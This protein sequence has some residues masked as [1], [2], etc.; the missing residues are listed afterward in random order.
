MLLNKKYLITRFFVV[1]IAAMALVSC[2]ETHAG[3]DLFPDTGDT[4]S[5]ATRK[6][7][8]PQGKVFIYMA[9]G[10]NNLVNYLS[11][12]IEELAA[13]PLP[14]GLWNDDIILVFS[15]KTA[16]YHDYSTDTSPTLTRLYRGWDGSVTRDTLMVMD[17]STAS[18]SA[19]TIN[20][21]LTYIHEM[22]PSSSYGMLMSSHGTGWAPSN[23]SNDP[24]RYEGYSSSDSGIWQTQR[25]D[26]FIAKPF[27]EDLS[28]DGA[29]A[30]KGIGVQNISSSE[31]ME[32]NVT[33]LADAIPMKMDYIIFDACLMG[34][35][36]VAYEFRDICDTM[37]CSQT[38]ILAD[39]MDYSTMLSYLFGG[40]V[41]DLR[42]FC[43]NFYRY[44]NS[45]SGTNRSATIS[46]IDCNSLEPLAAFCKDYFTNNRDRIANLEGAS[47][48]QKYF[49]SS[50]LGWF[51]DLADII[52]ES[53][54]SE[55]QIAL[56]NEALDE[57]IL[58]KAATPKFI[59]LPINSHCGISMYLPYKS[60][61]YLN[62]FYKTLEWN[63]ATGLVQ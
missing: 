23:Y 11:S 59:D 32:I 13:S 63:K 49:R 20:E 4:D 60:R 27:L 16:K 18:A 15:H 28:V 48:V 36:E 38:E 45:K 51:F 34:G 24:K 17:K 39:G 53:G 1:A 55:E 5:A 26:K 6:P 40:D 9:L 37:V 33:D 54:A 43:E 58:Y 2:S 42:G 8:Q 14:G 61:T 52:I 7:N 41:P 62:T 21:V 22:F 35:I 31:I 12:D 3:F 25:Q 50:N 56:M 47:S 44:Y 10:Y 57:C 30:V 19:E 29:P 46:L